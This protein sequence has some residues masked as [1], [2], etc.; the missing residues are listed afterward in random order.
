MNARQ[1]FGALAASGAMYTG[2][3][4]IIRVLL[5]ICSTI[6]LARLLT[7]GDFGVIAMASPVMGFL[8]IFQD[9]GLNQATVQSESISNNQLD[10]LFW[11][12]VL[13]SA[14]IAGV[15]LAISPGV[16]FFYHDIRAGY[17]TAAFS[18]NVLIGGAALQHAALLTR[19]MSF[20]VA[21]AI[22]IATS[23]TA[24]LATVAF[25]FFVRSY[26]SIWLG[27]VVSICVS[28][29]S[30]WIFVDWRPRF[31]FGF[32]DSRN[33]IRFGANVT[34]FNL[35][36]FMHR[37]AD[38]L[39][40]ARSW[41]AYQLGLYDRAYKLMTFPMQTINSP[42]SRV[43][44][45]ILSR[46]R[47]EP[48][49]L[50]RTYLLAIRAVL[51]VSV[52]GMAVAAS[53]SDRLVPFLLG[54][55]WAAAGPIFFWL[56][57]ASLSS[58]LSNA[59]GWLFI[60]CGKTQAYA[61]WGVFNACVT[62]TAFFVGLPWGAVGVARAY[63]ICMTVIIPPL[64][65]YWAP[66]GTPVSMTDLYRVQAEPFAAAAVTYVVVRQMS[67]H[68]TT[69]SLIGL[70]LPIAYTLVIALQ[71]SNERGRDALRTMAALAIR[72]ATSLHDRLGRSS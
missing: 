10:A 44:I 52:P 35:A 32:A 56:S 43:M 61:R 9:L 13:V 12:S 20:G 38:N 70:S 31:K 23:T 60:S 41:G 26:W 16:A 66:R 71:A 17:I 39:M 68:L 69:P 8:L 27:A 54:N 64:L 55:R 2:L 6:V 58:P 40:I 33:L 1:D 3:S 65:Y 21:A 62:V 42:L 30:L 37:N 15:M 57:L 72:M 53:I 34:I 47:A 4:Q 14:T 50:R 24:F 48:Q 11:L 19:R 59:T 5:S 63:A 51:T 45:P 22:D 28:T 25:A 49:R 36:N 29:S 46:L 7:P 18:L 67:P